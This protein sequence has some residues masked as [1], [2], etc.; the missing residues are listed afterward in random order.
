M[1]ATTVYRKTDL[2]AAT[3]GDRRSGLPPRGRM[4]LIMVDGQRNVQELRR[5][6]PGSDVDGL[7]ADLVQRELIQV[8]QH[9]RTPAPSQGSAPAEPLPQARRAAV[10]ALTDLMGPAATDLC[11]RMEASRTPE[12]FRAAL[13]RAE[14]ASARW[15]RPKRPSGAAAFAVGLR[16][17]I[18]GRCAA[19]N[20]WLA[21][22]N[23]AR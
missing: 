3:R 8:H 15:P 2:G 12:E 1:N 18:C 19:R 7:L 4:L 11:L 14:A 6:I 22:D 10:R 16:P 5:V 13:N 17:W 21:V 20:G 23:A 9:K